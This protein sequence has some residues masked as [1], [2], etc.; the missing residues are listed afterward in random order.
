[1]SKQYTAVDIPDSFPA[2]QMD[3]R[4]NCLRPVCD[5]QIHLVL[6]FHKPLNVSLLRRAIRLSLDAEPILGCQLREQQGQ[7]IWQRRHDLDELELLTVFEGE[8]SDTAVTDYMATP[9]DLDNDPLVQGVLFRGQVDTLCLKV[10]HIVADGGALS[11]YGE[12]LAEIYRKVEVQPEFYP[13]SNIDGQRTI[14]QITEEFSRPS[15][16]VHFFQL[17][18]SYYG[19][20]FPRKNWFFPTSLAEDS[21]RRTFVVQSIT[22]ELYDNVY[23]FAKVNKLTMNDVFVAAFYRAFYSTVQPERDVPLRVGTTINLRRYLPK[24]KK[25]AMCNL[26]AMLQLNIGTQLGVNLLDTAKRVQ[27]KMSSY[28]RYDIGMGDKRYV[29]FD[30]NCLSINV[31]RSLQRLHQRFKFFV[32]PRQAAPLFTNIGMYD[33]LNFDFGLN[34]AFEAYISPPVAFSPAFIVGINS[35]NKNARLICGFLGGDRMKLQVESLLD[36]IKKEL[37][38]G[39]SSMR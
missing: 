6:S 10:S 29:L 39:S 14:H 32:G 23:R 30:I 4:I 38:L 18:R 19:E 37:E 25:A 5:L 7:L 22:D 9:L 34:K 36:S 31:S 24:G 8:I 15:K 27:K 1:M 35:Y 20:L 12:L 11:E 33:G 13:Y 17:L 26:S 16:F 28:K 2:V 21:S 3:S